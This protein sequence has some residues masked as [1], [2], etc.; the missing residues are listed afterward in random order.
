MVS[1]TAGTTTTLALIWNPPYDP[2]SH[3]TRLFPHPR[4]HVKKTYVQCVKANHLVE[5]IGRG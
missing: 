5:E 4:E 1:H 2:L 3:Y